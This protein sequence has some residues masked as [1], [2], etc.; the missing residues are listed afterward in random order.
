M[1]NPKVSPLQFSKG[2]NL[3]KNGLKHK[4]STG[5]AVS[6]SRVK[7]RRLSDT[8]SRTIE[9]TSIMHFYHLPRIL[10]TNLQSIF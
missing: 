3:D 5:F 4:N 1:Q 6:W 8:L 9:K 2:H 10:H 7:A